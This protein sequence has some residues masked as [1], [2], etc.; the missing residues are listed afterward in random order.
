MFIRPRDVSIFRPYPEEMTN[1]GCDSVLG[2]QDL[3]LVRVAKWEG[4]IAA[5]Y[6]LKQ[7]TKTEFVLE[8]IRVEMAYRSRGLGSWM[9][10]HSIGLAEAWGGRSIEV[11]FD[12]RHRF[13][14]RRG[15][16]RTKNGV[17]RLEVQPE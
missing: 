15:F 3:D 4:E 2:A 10:G 6:Q 9:L 7:M 1:S 13:F 12:R 8:S 17:L 14:E 16:S 11:A 5:R